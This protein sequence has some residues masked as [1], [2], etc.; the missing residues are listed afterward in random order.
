MAVA[1]VY[2]KDN[3]YVAKDKF[4]S[5]GSLVQRRWR[6]FSPASSVKHFRFRYNSDLDFS[7]HV[8]GRCRHATM[9]KFQILEDCAAKIKIFYFVLI[10]L[11]LRLLYNLVSQASTHIR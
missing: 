1:F 10:K 11:M 8:R 7:E 3:V 4:T 5:P 2:S 9:R 6:S